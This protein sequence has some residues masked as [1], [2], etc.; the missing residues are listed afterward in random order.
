MRQ[1]AFSAQNA[2]K[3]VFSS[4]GDK[5]RFQLKRRFFTR[6]C[7]RNLALEAGFM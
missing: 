3:C 1:N 5:M 2:T 7:K 4:K 6:L